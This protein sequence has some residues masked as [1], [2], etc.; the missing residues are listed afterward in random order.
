MTKSTM[1][2]HVS[3]PWATTTSDVPEAG[4][5]VFVLFLFCLYCLYLSVGVMED[6]KLLFALGTSSF[7][8]PELSVLIR[9][10][11]PAFNL[12]SL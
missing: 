3:H 8:I 11:N 1:M 2:S 10:L 7:F 9:Y 4:C 6:Y 5:V 12:V